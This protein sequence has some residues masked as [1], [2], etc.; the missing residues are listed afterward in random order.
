MPLAH[1][2]DGPSKKLD[3]RPT[4]HHSQQV[5]NADKA[6]QGPSNRSVKVLDRYIL[7]VL[8]REDTNGG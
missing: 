5:R 3:N 8:G 4:T 1:A 2:L 7:V 6:G